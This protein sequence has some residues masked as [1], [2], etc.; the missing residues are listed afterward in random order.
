[1]FISVNE[2]VC[3]CESFEYWRKLR[4]FHSLTLYFHRIAIQNRRLDYTSTHS[5]QFEHL[6]RKWDWITISHYYFLHD[7]HFVM[8]CVGN[9][10][11]KKM[12]NA[13]EFLLFWLCRAAHLMKVH[14]LIKLIKYN[15]FRIFFVNRSVAVDKI[16]WKKSMYSFGRHAV[17]PWA[18]AAFLCTLCA[19]FHMRGIINRRLS[20]IVIISKLFQMWEKKTPSV[21]DIRQA[22]LTLRVSKMFYSNLAYIFVWSDCGDEKTESRFKPNTD[23]MSIF[24]YRLIS[25][26]LCGIDVNWGNHLI[27]FNWNLFENRNNYHYYHSAFILWWIH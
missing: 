8:E 23:W 10:K 26:K 12:S 27:L 17:S 5:P 16:I 20:T 4:P 18:W 25:S 7:V 3:V 13:M 11:K 2:C 9:K 14:Q 15:C 24:E 21:A 19:W 6:I 22:K 1:M